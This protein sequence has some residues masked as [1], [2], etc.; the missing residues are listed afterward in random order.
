MAKSLDLLIAVAKKWPQD[1][2]QSYIGQL[3][4]QVDELKELLRAL[5][6]L[7][8]QKQREINRKLDSGTRGGV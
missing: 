7:E 5:R 6:A 4:D 2:L 8:R 1:Q 3:D